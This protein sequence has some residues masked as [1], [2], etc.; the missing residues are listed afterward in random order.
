MSW[1]RRG[2]NG[3]YYT[4]KIHRNGMIVREYVGCGP[5]A[6]LLAA[7]D[8]AVHA[9]RQGEARIVREA[10]AEWHAE[11][12]T[13]RQICRTLGPLV[14]AVLMAEGYRR[15]GGEWRPWRARTAEPYT[16]EGTSP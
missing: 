15:H 4:R 9:Q 2:R 10:E 3:P 6:R 12:G 8:A 7:R 1:E 11:E 16:N 13:L 5:A 14:D